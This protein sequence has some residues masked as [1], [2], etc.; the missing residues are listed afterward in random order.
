M[1]MIGSGPAGLSCGLP[2]GATRLSGRP[3]SRRCRWPAACCASA[4]RP[5]ACRG[6]S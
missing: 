6:R 1:A 4:S 5:T 3:S 2:P